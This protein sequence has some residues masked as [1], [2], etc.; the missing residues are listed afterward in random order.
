MINPSGLSTE[1]SKRHKSVERS[2][3]PRPSAIRPG[4]QPGQQPAS[5]L[6][7]YT[8]ANGSG[9]SFRPGGSTSGGWPLARGL[10]GGRN[11]GAS[12]ISPGGGMLFRLGGAAGLVGPITTLSGMSELSVVPSM[13]CSL[14]RLWREQRP[15]L[16]WLR[17]GGSDQLVVAL[18]RRPGASRDGVG[19]VSQRPV[20]SARG[21]EALA[22]RSRKQSSSFTLSRMPW[23]ST[24]VSGGRG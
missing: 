20:A 23:H 22:W 6:G 10:R 5:G 21:V 12:V 24:P 11:L 8:R 17:T 1:L 2:K 13:L 18:V 4:L 3:P 19:Q 7:S 9:L 14:R 16:I 15:A